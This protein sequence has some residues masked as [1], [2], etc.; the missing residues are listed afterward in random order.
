MK[1]PNKKRIFKKIEKYCIDQNESKYLVSGKKKAIS[2][3]FRD[4]AKVQSYFLITLK[5]NYIRAYQIQ[6]LNENNESINT[7]MSLFIPTFMG[8]KVKLPKEIK[9]FLL[10]KK[11]K[12]YQKFITEFKELTPSLG[13]FD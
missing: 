1:I 12:D 13:W 6:Y 4:R 5:G 7:Y 8:E 3:Y 10:K 11:Y 2:A 9:S